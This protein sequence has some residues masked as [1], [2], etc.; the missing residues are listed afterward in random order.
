MSDVGC[1]M[2]DVGLRMADGSV[3]NRN[4]ILSNLNL[5]LRGSARNFSK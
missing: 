4:R 1:R 3:L 2:L 5:F